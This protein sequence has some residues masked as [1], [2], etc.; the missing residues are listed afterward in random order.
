MKAPILIAQNLFELENLV[1]KLI[2]NLETWVISN[3][4]SL[5]L[6]KPCY[7]IFAN[8]TKENLPFQPK[9]FNHLVDRKYSARF[10]GVIFDHNLTWREHI[11][12][13]KAKMSRYVGILY[14]FKKKRITSIGTKKNITGFSSL[15]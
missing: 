14:K 4:L 5:N 9:I 12:A 8:H 7:M 10:L 6:K 11:L 13:I 1:N 2:A 3:G 15:T